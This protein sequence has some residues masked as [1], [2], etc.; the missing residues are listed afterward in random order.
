MV[1][2]RA[3]KAQNWVG[4]GVFPSNTKNWWEAQPMEVSPMGQSK[5]KRWGGK[6]LCNGDEVN[7]NS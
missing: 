2:V 3:S 4:V 5:Q 7:S 1:G 6:I